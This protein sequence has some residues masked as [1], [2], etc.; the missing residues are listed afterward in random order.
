MLK[1]FLFCVTTHQVV[2]ERIG[3]HQNASYCIKMYHLASKCMILGQKYVKVLENYR[4]TCESI[5]ICESI[6]K[7]VKVL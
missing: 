2:S 6:E 7:Y 3:M 5:V 1:V 4:K